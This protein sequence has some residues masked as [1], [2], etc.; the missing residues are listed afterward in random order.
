MSDSPSPQRITLIGRCPTGL[1]VDKFADADQERARSLHLPMPVS[2]AGLAAMLI[3]QGHQVQ[4]ISPMGIGFDEM[5]ELRG[6][7]LAMQILPRRRPRHSLP[8]FYRTE[9]RLTAQLVHDFEPDIIHAHWTYESQLAAVAAGRKSVPVVTT[10]RDAPLTILRHDR[11]LVRVGQTV[12]AARALGTISRLSAPSPYLAASWRRAMLYRKPIRVIPNTI[13]RDITRHER[14]PAPEPVIL[15]VS[16]AAPHKNVR[17]LL[18]AFVVTRRTV[19]E[20]RLRLAGSGLESTSQLASWA[21]ANDLATR[22][23][24]LGPLSRDEVST[25]MHNAWLFAHSSREE[26]FGNSVLEALAIGTPVIAGESSGSLPWLLG[27]GRLGTLTDVTRPER[28]GRDMATLLLDGPPAQPEGSS[29][30]V[31]RRFSP[32]SVYP[33]WLTW[34]RDCLAGQS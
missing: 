34:Y 8:D 12:I 13:P 16:S 23:D 27:E 32:E 18:H 26:S 14:N 29:D 15:D 1:L 5:L 21:R 7:S 4:V 20:S 33:Q 9:S 19:P 2:V 30:E 22:V 24:F 28:F 31:R 3:D 17:A 6:P 10:A 11:D 25:E